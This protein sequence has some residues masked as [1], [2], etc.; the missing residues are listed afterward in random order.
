MSKRWHTLHR[1]SC[2]THTHKHT[3]TQGLSGMR[4]EA[5]LQSLDFVIL[6][7]NLTAA[8]W[9]VTSTYTVNTQNH[10]LTLSNTLS[11]S[12]SH[13][14]TLNTQ[15]QIAIHKLT[16][17]HLK[18]VG[19]KHSNGTQTFS[20]AYSCPQKHSLHTKTIIAT[21]CRDTHMQTHTHKQTHVDK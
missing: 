10:P 16:W 17:T 7:G 15:M 5:F 2:L 20:F 12:L 14:H 6:Q 11:L 21:S 13:T 1:W 18:H 3:C 19:I 8:A 9:V 4:A